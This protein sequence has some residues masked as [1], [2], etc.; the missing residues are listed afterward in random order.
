M[1]AGAE[2]K[3]GHQREKRTLDRPV[4]FRGIQGQ[5]PKQNRRAGCG[6]FEHRRHPVG[7]TGDRAGTRLGEGTGDL[8]PLAEGAGEGVAEIARLEQL[9]DWML[10][11]RDHRPTGWRGIQHQRTIGGGREV[12]QSADGGERASRC[13]ANDQGGASERGFP[14]FLWVF[15]SPC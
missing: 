12:D 6:K 9:R 5:V 8:E 4:G 7:K 3:F 1:W 11:G 10:G 13:R 14:E 2:E 15:T